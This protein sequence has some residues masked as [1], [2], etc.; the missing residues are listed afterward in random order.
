VRSF[1]EQ[2][3]VQRGGHPSSRRILHRLGIALV[4]ISALQLAGCKRGQEARI[5]EQ[6]QTGSSTREQGPRDFPIRRKAA[7]PTKRDS[8]GRY[9]IVF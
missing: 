4:V 7:D 6:Q 5:G 3:R 1:E 8:T 9:P 2:N